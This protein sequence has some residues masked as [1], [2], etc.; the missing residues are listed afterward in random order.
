MLRPVT[1]AD[2]V[3]PFAVVAVTLPGDE[4]TVYDVIGEPPL[5]V[6]AV[7]LTVACAFPATAETAVGGA[8]AVA[9]GVTLFDAADA[10]PVPALFFAV[11]VNV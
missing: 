8:G 9:A 11:T 10:G 5:S 7:Q 4:V 1:V 3:V 6:G 2:V